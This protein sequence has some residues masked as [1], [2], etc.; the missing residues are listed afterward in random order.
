MI[1][2]RKI[3]MFALLVLLGVACSNTSPQE[4]VAQQTASDENNELVEQPEKKAATTKI[5]GTISNGAGGQLYLQFLRTT[6]VDP[7]DTMSIGQDGSFSS[8]FSQSTIG[9]Y[10]LAISDQ[11]L[12]VLIVHPGDEIEINADAGN[13]YQTYSVKGSEESVRLMNLNKIL[14]RR[15]SINVVMQQAQMQNDRVAFQKALEQYD[16][17]M[18]EVN[19]KLRAFVKVNPASLSSLAALQNLNIEDDFDLY[20]EVVDGLAGKASGLDFYES[21]RIQV[22][23]LRKLAVGSP[24]PDIAL[25]QPNGEMLKL[26]DLKGQYVLIDFWASWCGPC[27]RENPNVKRVYE[28]YH[29]K[30]FEILGVS[31]DKNEKAWL[32]AIQQ[33]G[34]TWRH[35]SDLKYWQ[36]AVVPEYQVKGIPLT[37]L[38]DKD[39]VIIAKNL[40]GKSLEDKLAEIFVN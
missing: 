8:E 19:Q 38:V 29:D 26:S 6:G 40:R 2:I 21:L 17:V 28:K 35:I 3:Y 36:S 39:G 10:R 32:G 9:F 23:Q 13:L 25:P 34:L 1:M 11:N 7:I 20:K 24:A 12:L 4:E 16:P 27:R 30:G 22:V 14:M 18:A 37:Y 5:S 31:L 33:D 15:D